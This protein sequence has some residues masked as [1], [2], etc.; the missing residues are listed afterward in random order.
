MPVCDGDIRAYISFVVVNV[1][2]KGG[3]MSRG[4][5]RGVVI[6]YLTL[7]QQVVTTARRRMCRSRVNR[8]GNRW[9]PVVMLENSAGLPPLFLA[10]LRFCVRYCI[11]RERDHTQK[12]ALRAFFLLDCPQQT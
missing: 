4:T 6:R 1:K 11:D 12:T 5:R 9:T 7:R 3:T 10:T 2:A 8:T